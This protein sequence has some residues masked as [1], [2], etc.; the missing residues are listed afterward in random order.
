MITYAVL[1][2]ELRRKWLIVAG[3]ALVTAVAYIDVVHF[4]LRFVFGERG[5]EL[6]SYVRYVNVVA[7]PLFVLSFCPLLPAF[8]DDGP[9]RAWLLR[10]WTVSR[11]AAI[12]V[13]ALIAVYAIETPYLRPILQPNPKVSMRADFAPLLEQIRSSVGTSRVWIY[14]PHDLP[15]Q[16]ASRM[17]LFLLAPTP[18][19]VERSDSFL[20]SDDASIA[21]AWRPFDYVWIPS[22]L[23]VEEGAR[24]APFFA[25][26]ARPGLYHVQSSSSDSVTLVALGEQIPSY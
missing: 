23:T 5:L 11:R 3:G 26:V 21:T 1:R 4:S 2:A 24:L 22:E 25:G 20:A 18:A 7:L 8:R 19:V 12:C 9:E 15:N 6:P 17:V 14:F 16:F 10:G 13:A